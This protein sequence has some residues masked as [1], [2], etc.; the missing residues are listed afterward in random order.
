MGKIEHSSERRLLISFSGGET[1][2]LM[3][4]LIHDR[5]SNE[6]DEIVT[7][8]A[9]T[10][11][12]NE[13]TLE[14]V[15]RCDREFDW[16]VVWI[17]ADV[18]PARGVG[19]RAQVVDFQTA[20]RAGEPFE[21][22]IAKYGIPNQAFSHCS[23]ELK[24]RPIHRWARERGWVAGSYDTAI[25][26]RTDEI[27][28]MS[29]N[30]EAERLIYPLVSRFPFTKPAVNEFWTRQPFRLQLKG[31]QGNCKWCWK[32]SLR[33]HLTI[34]NESPDA[35]AFP[36]RMEALHPA[37]GA[38]F[39]GEPRR[40]FRGNLTVAELRHLAATQRFKPAEDDARSYQ[41]DLIDWLDADLDICGSESCEVDF[42]G[43]AK[44]GETVA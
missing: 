43:T 41:V 20:S 2:A 35:Y 3:A 31:Y 38:G 44:S 12:E 16:G 8:F 4:K 19:T 10:G 18:S 27:D 34:I 33:K 29:P 1:S 24:A 28:R 22:V 14:F 13:E 11:Q 26:I 42:G 21:A 5:M 39:T 25:G 17:E 37:T 7:V 40:F 6:Y 30:A 9:N 23:R 32:K 15:H 36:E